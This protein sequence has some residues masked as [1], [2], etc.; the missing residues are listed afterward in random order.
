MEGREES[1][2][3]FDPRWF[4]STK[5]Q[6]DVAAAALDGEPQEL[7]D[8]LFLGSRDCLL[9]ATKR[10]LLNDRG[11]KH[12]VMCCDRAPDYPKLF[13]YFVV[14]VNNEVSV[15][16]AHARYGR[17][18]CTRLADAGFGRSALSPCARRR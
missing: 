2:D 1:A 9:N 13:E 10:A 12:I 8:G 14:P 5:A 7:M 6:R 18:D 4:I 3:S 17:S 15:A 16:A 11:I